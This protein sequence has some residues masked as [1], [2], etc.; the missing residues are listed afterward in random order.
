MPSLGNR[1]VPPGVRTLQLGSP[2][3]YATQA[4]L[5]LETGLPDPN[6]PSFLPAAGQKIIRYLK[7]TN[8][9]AFVLFGGWYLLSARNWFK[10]PVR[11]GSDEE[12][13]RIEQEYGETAVATAPVS[14]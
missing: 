5:Y 4:T 13:A 8:G 11:Q 1:R 14:A 12:L 9:G 7:Q 10:G 6:D 2:F 3:D